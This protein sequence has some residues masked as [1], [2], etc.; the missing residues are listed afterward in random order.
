[1]VQPKTITTVNGTTVNG[2]TVNGSAAARRMTIRMTTESRDDNLGHLGTI[3]AI[4]GFC[5]RVL[6]HP[7]LASRLPVVIRI[8][9]W[10]A[11]EPFTAVT[12]V[13]MDRPLLAEKHFSG[14][15]RWPGGGVP[16]KSVSESD[17]CLPISFRAEM[18]FAYVFA[19][20][21]AHRMLI[22]AVV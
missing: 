17:E 11:T 1:M 22:W 15:H 16:K 14:N 2:T 3:L 8:V 12:I 9:M 20:D 10:D 21:L 4:F 13:P 18:D 19:V 7:F 5:G 6:Q